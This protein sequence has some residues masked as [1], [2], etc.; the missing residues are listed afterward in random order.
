MVDETTTVY[1]KVLEVE[2]TTIEPL[3]LVKTRLVGYLILYSPTFKSPAAVVKL[4]GEPLS[5][6][7]AAGAFREVCYALGNELLEQF[8]RP[9]EL[10]ILFSADL[11]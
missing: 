1:Y 6:S 8:V 9:C 3:D 7:A 4:L 10:G 11:H 2:S 5:A